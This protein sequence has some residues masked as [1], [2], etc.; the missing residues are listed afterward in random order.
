M[1][2]IEFKNVID[3]TPKSSDKKQNDAFRDERKSHGKQ[4]K[5]IGSF[6]SGASYYKYFPIA[7]AI[8]CLESSTIAFVEP[9]RWNDSYESLYYEADYSQVAPDYEHHPRVFATCA[10]SQKYDEPAW[11]IYSGEDHICVQFEL[12]RFQ[13]RHALLKSIGD[14]DMAYEGEVQYASRKVIETIGYRTLVS[15]KTGTPVGNKFHAEFIDR[16]GKPFCIDNYTN[17]LLLKRNDFKHEQETRFFIIKNQ[18][19]VDKAEK[20]TENK[21]EYSDATGRRELVQRGAVLV[22]ND[23]RW[24]DVLK[25]ITINA[26]ENS[27]PYRELKNTID[28][29]IDDTIKDPALNT[30]YK[31]ALKP[32]PY[33]VYGTR[34]RVI[35]IEK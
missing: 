14:K 2:T 11:R 28:L 7:T 24:L 4:Y 29:L 16:A 21:V 20:A 33:L 8:K 18:D 30:Q 25:S 17:L 19:V 13:F 9:T 26:E 27:L 6:A 35:T 23:I 1:A 32:I 10:T 15:A 12:D 5:Q 34:P 3:Y 31:N 22:L